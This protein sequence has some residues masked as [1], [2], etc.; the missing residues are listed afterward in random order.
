MQLKG[1]LT[2][3]ELPKNVKPHERNFKIAAFKIF[4]KVKKRIHNS[5]AGHFGGGK[6]VDF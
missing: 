1:H 5:R 2:S 3:S 6:P 4:K